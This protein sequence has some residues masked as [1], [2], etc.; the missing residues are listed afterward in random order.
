MSIRDA[1][2]DYLKGIR[3]SNEDIQKRKDICIECEFLGRRIWIKSEFPFIGWMPICKV[4]KCNLD[5]EIGAWKAPRKK[6][7]KNKWQ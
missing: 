1:L 5:G 2:G 3:I 7:P 4:C 6:C